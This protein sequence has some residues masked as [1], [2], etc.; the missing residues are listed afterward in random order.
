[1]VSRGTPRMFATHDLP[2][3]LLR[4]L[5]RCLNGKLKGEARCVDELSQFLLVLVVGSLHA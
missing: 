1:M 2:T 3:V 4:T 5:H